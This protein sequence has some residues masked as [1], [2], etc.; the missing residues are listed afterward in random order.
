MI[1]WPVAYLIMNR[2]LQ[3]YAY[4]TDLNMLT[5]LGAAA[6]AL[7]LVLATTLYQAARAATANPVDAL[8]Y[9]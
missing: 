6:M 5:F 1:A 4:H 2:W 9:E 3:G 7:V 8:Q